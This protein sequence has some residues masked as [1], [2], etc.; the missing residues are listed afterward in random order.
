MSRK[1][2]PLP[3]GVH[4]IK[5][6]G[7]Y[8]YY[9]QPGRGTKSAGPRTRLRGTPETADFWQH[10][11]EL[12]L[13]VEDPT[14]HPPGSF[15]DLIE[16]YLQSPDFHELSPSTRKEYRRHIDLIG[17]MW[18]PLRVRDLRP[19]HV[20]ELRDSLSGKKATANHLLR[21]LSRLISWGIP[22]EF[23][24]TN[25]CRHVPK[26]RTG[27]GYEPW[28]W[29]DIDHFRRHARP[30]MWHAA[31]LAL[32]T[33]QRQSDCL[34]MKW[35]DIRQ[36]VLSVRQSKTG[37][38]VWLPIHTRLAEILDKMPRRSIYILTN[39]HG[40]PWQTG[41]QASWRKHLARPEMRVLKEKGLV[42][43]GLRKSAVVFLLEAG[44]TDA[45]VSAITGQTR[46]MV[47]H[48]AAKIRQQNLAVE[49]I[50][51]WEE[52]GTKESRKT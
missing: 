25:P 15:A 43:H 10:L 42:F 20:L 23:C 21:V 13:T 38:Q 9:Y 28:S 26:Y 17:K 12:G 24:E 18:G 22:R 35:S 37:K 1:Q 47:E 36:G 50:L 33:G 19:R 29:E 11:T 44:C 48:Y 4:R 40:Q 49:A 34:K 3:P 6:R 52:R 8:Y 31:A 5:S 39:S 2:C 32:Y 51:K 7:R 45:E 14:S 27:P 41:F 30:D 46:Q 16:K